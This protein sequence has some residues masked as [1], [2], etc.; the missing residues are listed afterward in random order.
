VQTSP[1]ERIDL[2]GFHLRRVADG[3]GPMVAATV[4][5]NVDRLAVWMPWASTSTTVEFHRYRTPQ[6]VARWDQGVQFEYLAVHTE[7]GAH[8]G[9]FGLER[10]I[11]P[12]ALEL[13]YWLTAEASGHGY[14]TAAA[15]ALT[16]AGLA[17][18]DIH[19]MEIHCDRANER[20]RRIPE[21]L[22]YRL[23]RLEPNELDAPGKTGQCMI[24]VYPDQPV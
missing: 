13:G 4:A 21:R 18:P 8:L 11:G 9:T 14:A 1:P 20:S 2:D 19:R 7:T 10:R 16:Q 12:G 3:D 22:G 15:R 5:A 24:W 6:T 17:L 23:D